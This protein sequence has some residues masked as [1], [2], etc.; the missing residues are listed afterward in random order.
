MKTEVVQQLHNKD[1]KKVILM[2]K[3]HSPHEVVFSP[4][5]SDNHFVNVILRKRATG[6]V[7][8][9]HYILRSDMPS[10]VSMY[11][12]DGFKTI[13]NNEDNERK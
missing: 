8:A 10:W 9:T 6:Q 3:P 1:E 5:P 13:T 11:E 4:D 2:R 7:V 12:G